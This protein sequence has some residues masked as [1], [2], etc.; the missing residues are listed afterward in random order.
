M[1]QL[2]HKFLIQSIIHDGET[3]ISQ[4]WKNV[5][6]AG[7]AQGQQVYHDHRI[8]CTLAVPSPAEE[9]NNNQLKEVTEK[10][11]QKEQEFQG[12]MELTLRTTNQVKTLQAQ[13]QQKDKEVIQFKQTISELEK[14][15]LAAPV[16]APNSAIS[17]VNQKSAGGMTVPIWALAVLFII[18]ILFAKM[19][20]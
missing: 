10:L 5:E 18:G 2:K 20:L 14:A 8:S 11:Q 15:A 6:T 12:L 17:E 7:K 4:Y 19:F 9:A 3:E 1:K 13:L 16:S